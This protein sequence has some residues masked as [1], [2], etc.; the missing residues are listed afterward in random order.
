MAVSA[1]GVMARAPFFAEG[2]ALTREQAI[3]YAPE[4]DPPRET[5]PEG[6]VE[7]DGAHIG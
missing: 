2:C 4:T 3:E 7:C 5:G 1:Q 6:P